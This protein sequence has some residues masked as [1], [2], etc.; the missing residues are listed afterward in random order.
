MKLAENS[1][2]AAGLNNSAANISSVRENERITLA[3]INYSS[4]RAR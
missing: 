4:L 2:A 3:M 1:S